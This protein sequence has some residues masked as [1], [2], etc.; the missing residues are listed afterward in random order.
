MSQRSIYRDRIRQRKLEALCE[1]VHEALD[2]GHG[3]ESVR[4]AVLK[5]AD[6]PSIAALARE[7]EM[8]R[9]HL[10]LCFRLKR[11]AASVRRGVEFNLLL[12][13]G[14]M[15]RVLEILEAGLMRRTHT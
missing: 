9:P 1:D 4:I 2:K 15:E 5:M 7:W 10:S 6:Q 11:T 13:A 12:P 3:V 14:G 8:D